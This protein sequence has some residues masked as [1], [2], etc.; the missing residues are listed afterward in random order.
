MTSLIAG[1]RGSNAADARV[2]IG[3]SV[4]SAARSLAERAR[5]LAL[6]SASSGTI[7]RLVSTPKRGGSLRHVRAVARRP[8]APAALGEKGFG[9]A[10]FERMEGHDHQA[11]ARLEHL[12]GRDQA[13]GQFGKL[14][15]DEDAQR[16]ERAGGRVDG[17]RPR[18]HDACD[19]VCERARGADRR[20][21]TGGDD[22]A[23]DGA[24]VAFFAEDRQDDSEVALGGRG[25]DIGRGRARREPMRMSSGPSWRK[26]NPRSASSSCI[27]ETPRS[28]TTPST[29]S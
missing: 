27:E 28:K 26:E 4:R 19:D 7:G 2:S 24:R 29:A 12:F 8:A 18:V 23:G 13:R 16:L 21:G 1:T 5:G 9:D 25:H 20:I 17:A 11:S 10:V 6:I 22:G 3:A 15:V 14:L